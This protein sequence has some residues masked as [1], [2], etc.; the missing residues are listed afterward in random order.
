ML[1]NLTIFLIVLFLGNLFCAAQSDRQ[2]YEVPGLVLEITYDTESKPAYIYV[3]NQH[4]HSRGS[5]VSNFRRVANWRQTEGSIPVKA[6]KIV[7][8]PE[9]N[10]VKVKVSVLAGQKP[11]ENEQAIADYTLRENEKIIVNNL[12]RF[13]IEPFEIRVVGLTLAVS[14]LPLIVNKTGSLTVEKLE[15]FN[16]ETPSVKLVLANNSDKAVSALTY[17]VSVGKS[18]RSSGRPENLNGGILVKPG[19][20]FQ[21]IIPNAGF[22]VKNSVGQTVSLEPNRTITI[23]AVVFEDGSF[24]GED[25]EAARFLVIKFARKVQTKKI[26]ALL[27]Q[28]AE[29]DSALGELKEKAENLSAEIDENNFDKFINQFAALP[30]NEKFYLRS[31]TNAILKSLKSEFIS[32]LE[33]DQSQKKVESAEI[34]NLLNTSKK[35]YQN[36]LSQLK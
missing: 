5:L 32:D 14:D 4:L 33:L 22:G 30:D 25:A 1:R 31:A 15:L 3:T 20:R 12:T 10:A 29:T 28:T 16:S 27:E 26:L 23:S 11:Y 9:G 6:V 8:L 2:I 18:L 13:G 35:K 17:K 19:E 7:S 34:R 24:E 21:A 36:L